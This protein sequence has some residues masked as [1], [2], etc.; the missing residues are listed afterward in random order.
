[1][2][3]LLC[4]ITLCVSQVVALGQ[5]TIHVPGDAPTIQAGIVQAQN[6]DTILVSPGTYNEN[7]DFLGKNITVTTGANSSSSASQTILNGVQDGPPTVWFHSG[8]SRAAV[9]NG[10]TIQNGHNSATIQCLSYPCTEVSAGILAEGASPTLANNLV[11][12][13]YGCNVVIR[14]G[15]GPQF[16]GNEVTGQLLAN[17][18][19]GEVDQGFCFGDGIAIANATSVRIANNHIHGN[20]I[21]LTVNNAAYGSVGVAM[22]SADEVDLIQ[23]EIHDNGRTDSQGHPD[24]GSLQVQSGYEGHPKLLILSGNLVYVKHPV[25]DNDPGILL[26]GSHTGKDLPQL[27]QVSNSFIG[28]TDRLDGS[29]QSAILE[30]NIVT[31][32]NPVLNFAQ[33]GPLECGEDCDPNHFDIR[34]NDLFSPGVQPT[35]IFPVGPTNLHVDPLL[36]DAANGDLH[37]T[38]NSP[39][40]YAGDIAAPMLPATDLDGKNRTVCGKV[41]MG[42]YQVHPAPPIGLGA[43]PNPVAGG[44]PVTVTATVTGNCNV[45]TGVVTFVDSVSG[46]APGGGGPATIGTATLGGTVIGTATGNGVA[47]AALSTSFLTVGTHH[48]TATY[49]GDFNFDPGTSN[50]VDLTVTGLPSATGLTVQPNPARAFQPV[51]LT[52]TVTDPFVTVTGN[53]TFTAAGANGLVVLGTAPLLGGAAAITTSQLGAGAYAVTATFNATTQFATSSATVQLQVEGAPTVTALRT[54]PNPSLF[55]QTVTLSA[56]VSPQAVAGG[57]PQGPVLFRDGGAPLG[58]VPVDANGAAAFSTSSLAI[59]SHNLSA[60]YGGSG[61]FNGSTSPIVVQVV[62]PVTAQLALTAQPNPAHQG[63]TV[64]LRLTVT[65]NSGAA[66]SGTAMF[67]EGTTPLGSA[68]VSAGVAQL[69]VSTFGLGRHVV[70]A[71]FANAAAGIAFTAAT[72]TVE[73]MPYDFAF[74]SSGT[75]LSIPHS[76]YAVVTLT[77]SP[78]GGYDQPV[79]LS[80]GPLPVNAECAFERDTTAPLS[81]GPQQVK[82][83]V[84][85]NVLLKWG[86]EGTVSRLEPGRG[87]GRGLGGGLGRELGSGLL[88][89]GVLC[90][91][92]R[93]RRW[94]GGC[95]AA[96]AVCAGALWLQGCSGKE[97]ASTPA[98]SYR[99]TVTAQGAAGITH[100]VQLTV[101]VH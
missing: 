35:N 71:T 97:P 72:V 57:R 18:K 75:T 23:N 37:E 85:A 69:P 11:Q 54:S 78:L 62:Q 55:G 9:L 26:S 88:A 82:L 33:Y 81:G 34:Y 2:K 65:A 77:A 14:N 13:N 32:T 61:D 46:A 6:G 101:Q 7:I 80:C 87:F 64:T 42:A 98:G 40:I 67:L 51:T 94:N 84:N 47:A 22:G 20:Y 41:D 68:P 73:V 93:R 36:R 24:D 86:P 4:L 58:T 16:I 59:G 96:V 91:G 43:T 92:L 28:V 99:V 31:L 17:N 29:F 60:S 10:F 45:P 56:T 48:I 53:V 74:T 19:V 12:R 15:A 83:L 25:N 76:G 1:M 63:E 50:A 79:H 89:A 100:S 3:R 95:I 39:T 38:A 52:A 30:D 70:T 21:D 49:P 44:S 27:V 8:E 5:R 90:L 66:V